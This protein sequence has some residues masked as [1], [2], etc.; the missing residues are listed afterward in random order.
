M[1]LAR[2]ACVVETK[3][4]LRLCDEVICIYPVEIVVDL[5]LDWL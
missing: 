4:L 2:I 1:D 3:K 5:G